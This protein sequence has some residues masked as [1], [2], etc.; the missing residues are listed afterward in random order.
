MAFVN[1]SLLLGGAF[2]A[3]PVVL[4][5]IMRQKPKQLIFPA[6]RFIQQR[7]I[8]NQRRL[9]LRHWILLALRCGAIA[10]VAL[11]LARPSVASAE[12]S[13]WLALALVAG[14]FVVVAIL[15]V[16]AGVQQAPKYLTGSL[17][18]LAGI[19]AIF[20]VVAGVRSLWGGAPVIGDQEAPVAAVLVVDTSPRM[21]YRHENRTRLEVARET[22]D[23]LIRQLPADSE[24]AVID[25][26]SG[27]GAFAVDRAAAA[28]MVERV[29]PTGTPRPLTE[30]IATAIQLARQ[31]EHTRKEVYV[32]TDLAQAAW[33]TKAG[34]DLAG[35]NLAKLL[36]ENRN[37]LLY[38]IDVGV[39]KPRNFALGDL[40]LSTEVVPQ[41]SELAL[42]VEVR[43]LGPG[44]NK[45]VELEL[46]ETDPTLPIIRDG[47]AVLPKAV[48]RGSQDVKL[49][50][51]AAERVQFV[52]RKLDP[53]AHQG[54]VRIL[55]EDGLAL[56]DVRYFAVEVQ[57]AWPVLVVAPPDV[58]TTYFVEAVAPRE[59]RE[60]G[61]ARFN[62]D[63]IDQ[64]RLAQS[65]LADY[66][67]VVLL[68]P[69]PLTPDLW[70]KLA[71]YAEQ[72]GGVG[73]FLGHNAQ[74]LA[75][76]QEPAAI[77]LLGGKLTRQT[78]AGDDLFIAP[79]SFDHPITAAFRQIETNVP[80]DRFPIHFHWNLDEL[81]ADARTIIPFGNNKPA[82]VEH[83]VG[84]GRVLTLTTPVSDPPRPKGYEAWNRLATGED[85]W[86]YLMLVNE[87]L[88][89]LVGSGQTR[90]NLQA[91]EAAVLPND[92]AQY[93]A[94]YQL[95]TPLDQPQDLLARDGRLTVRFT[96]NPGAYRLRGQKAGPIVRGFAVNLPVET[97]D[98]ARLPAA[99]LDEL[100]GKGRYQLARNKDEIDRA[101]GN[102]RVGSEFYPLLFTLVAMVLGLEHVLGNRFYKKDV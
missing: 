61:R 93:P 37:V 41:G 63:V 59:F 23:W 12:M 33:T 52:L 26:R 40:T 102:D 70:T 83:R 7:R 71:E 35:D 14:G 90:L 16:A 11:A 49:A 96:D 67:A 13:N 54:L 53:G 56:D 57:E 8:A 92:E 87:S 48:R 58:A 39:E 91:G 5:L 21:D 25:S 62:C 78:R 24:V 97:S 36:A 10:L 76:F 46:E 89:Y 42:E 27:S 50:D 44:G 68:D 64:S 3:I 22:A 101:V 6:V 73:V 18:A 60:T 51:G 98:L 19:L 1:L 94:R 17:A 47:K 2:V 75:P 55:G 100:L 95:F 30:T 69:A 31:H 43:A 84:R 34:N 65:E 20:L 81:A 77:G 99:R 86:P 4:H 38:V 88:L 28:K 66:R 15:A 72:G 80:W 29:H 74:P 85:A 32:F 9:Q 82:L 45:T 79:R